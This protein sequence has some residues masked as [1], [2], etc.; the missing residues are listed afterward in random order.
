MI[1]FAEDGHDLQIQGE[2]PLALVDEWTSGQVNTGPVRGQSWSSCRSRIFSIWTN[3]EVGVAIR[4]L[5]L[6]PLT[7]FLSH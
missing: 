7:E 1:L 6:I 4:L 3:Q 5:L 2:G